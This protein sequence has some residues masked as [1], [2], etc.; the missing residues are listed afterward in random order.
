MVVL[1]DLEKGKYVGLSMS[2]RGQSLLVRQSQKPFIY[3]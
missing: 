1:I 2:N 3:I